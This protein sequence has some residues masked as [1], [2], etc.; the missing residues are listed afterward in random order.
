MKGVLLKPFVTCNQEEKFS[1]YKVSNPSSVYPVCTTFGVG[2][3]LHV[4]QEELEALLEHISSITHF[5]CIESE[6]LNYA[7]TII[8]S[9]K[10]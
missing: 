4:V 10:K 7:C 8:C 1:F 6:Q 5:S 3:Y 2:H 9:W